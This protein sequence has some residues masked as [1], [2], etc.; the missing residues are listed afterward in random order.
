MKRFEKVKV[1]MD[2]E[3]WEQVITAK[4]N[5]KVV[6]LMPFNID[7]NRQREIVCI[8]TN[9]DVKQGEVYTLKDMQ[10]GAWITWITLKE[11]KSTYN[12]VKFAEMPNYVASLR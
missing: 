5:G 7:D 8:S 10:V 6:N 3:T 11:T 12:S 1:T 9:A 4:E 2:Q